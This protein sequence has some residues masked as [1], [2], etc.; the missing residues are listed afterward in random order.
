MSENRLPK[1][2][3]EMWKTTSPPED[4]QCKDC[5]FRL[6]PVTVAGETVDRFNYG[7][8]EIFRGTQIKPHEV[9]W[10]HGACE[11]YEQEKQ[12][13]DSRKNNQPNAGKYLAK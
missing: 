12:L 3:K 4:I 2:E 6:R 11:Y 13:A 9:L 1:W 10:E 8:C 5:I 7:N